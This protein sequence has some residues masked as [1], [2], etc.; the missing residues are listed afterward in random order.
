MRKTL[1]SLTKVQHSIALFTIVM[2]ICF[3]NSDVE[4]QSWTRNRCCTASWTGSLSMSWSGPVS[5]YRCL[6]LKLRLSFGLDLGPCLGRSLGL[7]LGNTKMKIYFNHSAVETQS[8][9]MGRYWSGSQSWTASRSWSW[10]ASDIS[11]S[12]SGYGP[13]SLSWSGAQSMSR[14]WSW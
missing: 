12:M 4:T 13:W 7:G 1:F 8:W 6:G 9:T 3:N 5:V 10:S 11:W 14:S 2:K